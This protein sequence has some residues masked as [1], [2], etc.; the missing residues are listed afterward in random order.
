MRLLHESAIVRFRHLLEEHG[1][2]LQI[3]A[4]V[5]AKLIECGLMLKTSTVVD[6]TLDSALNPTKNDSGEL[7]PEINQTKKGN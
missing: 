7:D 5:N 2:G 4:H 6:A 1:L 3:L